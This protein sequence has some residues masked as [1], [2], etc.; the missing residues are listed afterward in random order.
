MVGTGRGI[1]YL[2]IDASQ[3]LNGQ[4]VIMG[5]KLYGILIKHLHNWIH[6]EKNIQQAENHIVKKIDHF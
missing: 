2:H 6:F 4:V 3:L 1:L 5:K